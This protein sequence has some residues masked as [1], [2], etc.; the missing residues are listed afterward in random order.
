MIALATSTLTLTMTNMELYFMSRDAKRN[1]FEILQRNILVS[2][3]FLAN[4][5]FK[6][7]TISMIFTVFNLWSLL[8]VILWSVMY[9]HLVMCLHRNF[10][11]LGTAANLFLI[12]PLNTIIVTP[13]GIPSHKWEFLQLNLTKGPPIRYKSLIRMSVWMHYCYFSI[14]LLYAPILQMITNGSAYTGHFREFGITLHCILDGNLC[15]LT[16]ITWIGGLLSC[17]IVEFYLLKFP[18][19]LGLNKENDYCTPIQDVSQKEMENLD[20]AN[21]ACDIADTFLELS[22][23]IRGV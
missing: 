17:M 9:H 8:I 4:S 6:I 19:I 7:L 1:W 21:E 23:N 2:P 16:L 10:T 12:G 18:Q 3:F 15:R 20:I 5:M 14:W 11:Y 13:G 22:Q